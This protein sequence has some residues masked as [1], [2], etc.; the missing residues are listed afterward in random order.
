MGGLVG[1]VEGELVNCYTTTEVTAT[2]SKPWASSK[3]N[4]FIGS[5][6]DRI[7]V[8]NCGVFNAEKP[9]FVSG[10][11]NSPKIDYVGVA[12]LKTEN[13]YKSRGWDFEKIWIVNPDKYSYPILRGVFEEEQIKAALK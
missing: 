3:Y 8:K 12:D 4:G 13:T 2:N 11:G 1:R 5:V 10:D 6:K 7:T 9:Y